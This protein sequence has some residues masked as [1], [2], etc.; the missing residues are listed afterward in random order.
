MVEPEACPVQPEEW[1][2]PQP[3]PMAAY[4]PQPAPIPAPPAPP[5]P[6]PAPMAM[7]GDPWTIVVPCATR[8]QMQGVAAALKAQ[9]VVG[10]I[11]HGTVGQ[12]YERM[13]GGY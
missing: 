8:E 9:G 11:M 10:T 12:V 7:A 13:N 6:V 3:A 4:E 5:A 1:Q 2:D